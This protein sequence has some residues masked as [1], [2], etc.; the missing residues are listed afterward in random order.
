MLPVDTIDE[1]YVYWDNIKLI[2][3]FC[4]N[5]E[6]LD[7]KSLIRKLMELETISDKIKSVLSLEYGY[8][9]PD[10]DTA[11]FEIIDITKS[12]IDFKS[13]NQNHIKIVNKEKEL[14]ALSHY[15]SSS[16]N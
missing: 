13:L 5:F 10:L 3:Q 2:L 15:N 8:L 6:R 11:D 12:D 14:N 1:F 4:Q 7:A 16:Y 9:L